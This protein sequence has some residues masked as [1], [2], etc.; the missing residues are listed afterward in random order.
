MMDKETRPSEGR[1][2][3]TGTAESPQEEELSREMPEAASGR[4]KTPLG[5]T[6]QHSDAPGP[7]GLS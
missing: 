5:S 3:T 6:D 2:N 1:P 7:D 4:G